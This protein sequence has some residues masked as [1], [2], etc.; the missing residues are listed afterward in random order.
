MA[1]EYKTDVDKQRGR[2]SES[3]KSKRFAPKLCEDRMYG[4]PCKYCKKVEKL[5][6]SKEEED[7]D[8]ASQCVA[9]STYYSNVWDLNDKASACQIYKYG[10]ENWRTLQDFLTDD[11]E[12]VDFTNPSKCRP[13]L[14][15]RKGTGR[16]NTS[17]TLKLSQK[18]IVLPEKLLK[19]MHP[20]HNILKILEKESVD[21]WI[22]PQGVSKLAFMP[23]WSKEAEGDFY[24]ELFFH[25]NTHL[26]DM[27][28]ETGEDEFKDEEEEDM[29]VG[30]G[31]GEDG[32]LDE[33]LPP[34]ED[35]FDDM[36]RTELKRYI[37][38]NKV[39]VRVRKKMTDD[40]IRNEIRSQTGESEE[41]FEDED[42]I[43]Y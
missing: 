27:E 30:G 41:P 35:D 22:P 40:D 23:P 15:K 28:G 32:D 42:D 2:L 18:S 38:K 7:N 12:G 9:R 20:L 21:V 17:Y 16:Y 10:I 8:L 39:N 37:I 43:E 4:K 36:N 25:W 14:L 26:L 29:G 24:V 5:Y 33:E 3:Y 1:Y 31:E 6:A 13:I 34:E 11:E 19:R